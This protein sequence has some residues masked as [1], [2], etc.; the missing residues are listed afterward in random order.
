MRDEAF[1]WPV[2]ELK[3]ALHE[4]QSLSE[5][6]RE[7]VLEMMDRLYHALYSTRPV[8]VRVSEMEYRA[9]DQYAREKG[10]SKS[11]A[12]RELIRQGHP[13]SFDLWLTRWF[14]EEL[15]KIG[16]RKGSLAD[17]LFWTAR[18]F[19]EKAKEGV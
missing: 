13:H 1:D 19:L 9:I 14:V 16:D 2:R 17:G 18:S 11:E 5:E 6:E 8:Y 15:P 12:I 3:E 7:E 10:L 4:Y